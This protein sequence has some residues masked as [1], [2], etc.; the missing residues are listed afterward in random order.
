MIWDGFSSLLPAARQAQR[1]PCCDPGYVCTSQHREQLYAGGCSDGVFPDAG[2][3][4]GSA[5]LCSGFN[6]LLG[7]DST[8]NPKEMLAGADLYQGLSHQ[9]H[10]HLSLLQT[11]KQEMGKGAHQ[12][13]DSPAMQ[14]HTAALAA[15]GT[16]VKPKLGPGTIRKIH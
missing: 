8:I 16:S 11:S 2:R 12:D 9:Q 1:C 13:R 10:S 3:H 4:A 6:F 14:A 15:R 7:Q 5:A